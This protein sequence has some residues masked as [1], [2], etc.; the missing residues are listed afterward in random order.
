MKRI[1]RK[2][3]QTYGYQY[4]IKQGISGVVERH[5]SWGEWSDTLGDNW[6]TADEAWAQ[7]LDSFTPA[8]NLQIRVVRVTVTAVEHT[9][10]E[11]E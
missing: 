7:A 3:K 5:D 6:L 4:R 2:E 1:S 10:E 11:G 9:L 8:E